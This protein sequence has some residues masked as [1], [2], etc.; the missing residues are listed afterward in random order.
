MIT[1]SDTPH[2]VGLLW[3][4]DQPDAPDNTQ[5]SQNTDIQVPGGIRTHNPRKQAAT[6][7]RLRLRGHWGRQNTSLNTVKVKVQ[8]FMKKS[9][10]FFYILRTPAISL[11]R[12][13]SCKGVNYGENTKT[14]KNIEQKKHKC[15]IFDS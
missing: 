3:T 10:S 1:R 9:F 11:S 2:S 14:G 8:K 4:S 7:P 13:I 6:N 5:H 15:R 12:C